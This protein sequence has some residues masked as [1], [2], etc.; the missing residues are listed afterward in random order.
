MLGSSLVCCVQS[1]GAH[2]YKGTR[3]HGYGQNWQRVWWVRNMVRAVLTTRTPHEIDT[4]RVARRASP[5]T[6]SSECTST[7]PACLGRHCILVHAHLTSRQQRVPAPSPRPHPSYSWCH[8]MRL[9]P[10]CTPIGKPSRLITSPRGNLQSSCAD[11]SA[12]SV[13]LELSARGTFAS[14]APR[15]STR[16]DPLHPPT[17]TPTPGINLDILTRHTHSLPRPADQPQSRISALCCVAHDVS[18][19]PSCPRGTGCHPPKQTSENNSLSPQH[20]WV[21]DTSHIVPIPNT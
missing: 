19:S 3:V 1:S 9:P 21:S 5:C 13:R 4:S 14:T 10:N 17:P 12:W 15:H 8:G 6:H 18:L 2:G 7:I 20:Q 16:F 11:C